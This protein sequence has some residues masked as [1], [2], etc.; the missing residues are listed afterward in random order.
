MANVRC[1]MCSKINSPEAQTCAYCGARL[2]P[3]LPESGQEVNPPAGEAESSDSAEDW[4]S[5]LRLG[6]K[7]AQAPLPETPP[8]DPTQPEG[9]MPDWLSRIRERART[10]VNTPETSAETPGEDPDWMSDLRSEAAEPPAD[11]TADLL[12]R[13]PGEAEPQLDDWLRSFP[14]QT[15]ASTPPAAADQFSDNSLAQ[16][17]EP[18]APQ[19]ETPGE[20]EWISKLSAWQTDQPNAPREVESLPDWMNAELSAP[21]AQPAQDAVPGW[22]GTESPLPP[23]QTTGELLSNWL[24]DVPSETTPTGLPDWLSTEPDQP[25][26]QSKAEETAAA[27]QEDS[28]PDW[29]SSFSA[30]QVGEQPPAAPPAD[31]SA[32]DV[33]LPDWLAEE[34][35]QAETAPAPEP[36]EWDPAAFAAFGATDDASDAGLKFEEPAAQKPAAQEP[37]ADSES[38][39]IEPVAQ[40]ESETYPQSDFSWLA[41]LG[42]VG[43]EDAS[44]EET[45]QPE[46]PAE[47]MF[48]QPASADESPDWLHDFAAQAPGTSDGVPAL[49]DMNELEAAQ[50]ADELER[51]F[52][53]VDLPDWLSEESSAST[54]A[55]ATVKAS[56]PAD[57]ELA[58][59]DLPEWVKDMRPIESVMP[60]ETAAAETSQQVEK[61][62][63]LAGLRGVLPA[64]EQI[65]RY[66]K[67][68]VYSAKLRVTEKQRSQSS[69]LDSIVN[70]E[71][72]PLLI[73][74]EGSRAPRALAR[75]LVALLFIAVF[76]GL[77]FF[78][79]GMTPSSMLAP[80]ELRDMFN[81]IDQTT[82]QSAPVL[83][84]VDFEPGRAGEMYF[85][86][87]PVIEHLMAKKA[88]IVVLSTVPTGPALAQRLLQDSANHLQSTTQQSY[89][90]NEQTVNLGYLPGGTISL[91]EFAQLPSRAA[92]AT[93]EGN[94]DIWDQ[95]YLKNAKENGMSGFS[96]VI[97]L[98]D[99][100]ETGR[101]WVE[102]VQ[103][104]MDKTPLLMVT[105]AQAAPLL[106]PY[107]QSRQINGMVDGLL[108]GVIYGQFRQVSTPDVT[109][110][111]EV[112]WESYQVGIIV[113][114]IIILVGGL[115]SAVVALT[116][117]KGKE[118]A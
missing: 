92:P 71:S 62:G 81:Q 54:A 51:S 3:I 63:P 101:A 93:L 56:E 48:A 18:A 84:A 98:T 11:A 116:R 70:Q 30:D 73:A 22:I 83:I 76:A 8:A 99:S 102:Q 25:A 15:F 44:E 4:L 41:Q 96:E 65:S 86:S 14:D 21:P 79:L 95:P 75:I 115:F 17:D 53:G 10:E 20:E 6:N 64:E 34:T 89:D 88:R 108:G 61:A 59:A 52:S 114:M 28:L 66:R 67:P 58:R 94:F 111:A 36:V 7:D 42:E 77:R 43:E 103:P 5:S 113:A 105:S 74:P 26:A 33:S 110:P 69:L 118:G 27:A 35:P 50:P 57:E 32:A 100:A 49:L 82:L 90:L 23:T 16:A 47:T 1:P 29:F 13:L 78:P 106:M 107:V 37:A 80:G 2:K 19:P 112:Y 39:T 24:Q 117:R 72:Q 31:I 109:T 38:K 55:A 9:D 91:L 12:S 45:A 46:P 85:A 60:G 40:E 87:S 97:V 68:P 104:S